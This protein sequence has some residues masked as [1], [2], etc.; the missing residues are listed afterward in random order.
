MEKV[1]GVVFFY[2]PW[3]VTIS[4]PSF[5]LLNSYLQ[6]VFW[7]CVMA[8]I[9]LFLWILLSRYSKL[10]IYGGIK[11]KKLFLVLL[12]CCLQLLQIF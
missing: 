6:L 12:F 9:A 5:K 10:Y 4:N 7:G 1:V 8:C 3:S 2:R 11:K